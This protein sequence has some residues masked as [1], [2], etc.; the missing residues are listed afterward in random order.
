M[1]S[2]LQQA[3]LVVDHIEAGNILPPLLV[4][5][6]LARNPHITMGHIRGYVARQASTQAL[7][8]LFQNYFSLIISRYLQL[9]QETQDLGKVREQVSKLAAET[10]A[11]QAE[12]HKLKTQVCTVYGRE[13]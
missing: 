3:L 12:A 9:S 7:K 1:L 8:H 13:I 6:S 4:L 5:Q 10:A 11:L 2:W